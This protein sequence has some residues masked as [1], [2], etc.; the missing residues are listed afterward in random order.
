MSPCI[1]GVTLGG[2]STEKG[3]RHPTIG[4]NVVIGAGAKV[5]GA[6]TVG[7]CSRIGANAVVVEDVP[8]NAVVVGCA[9]ACADA[10]DAETDWP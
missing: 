6:I 8:E 3:K 7:S 9:R 4:D 10:Q 2:V 1:T 5:L